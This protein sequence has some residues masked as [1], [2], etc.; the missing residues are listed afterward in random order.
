MLKTRVAMMILFT[1][2]STDRP[3]VTLMP[4]GLGSNRLLGLTA[5]RIPGGAGR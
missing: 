4:L 3:R 2:A 1:R 5:R